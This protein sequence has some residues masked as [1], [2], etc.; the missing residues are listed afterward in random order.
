M[1][2][3]STVEAGVD[4]AAV[5][6][7]VWG[8]VESFFPTMTTL[9]L[10]VEDD[11]TDVDVVLHEGGVVGLAG[12]GAVVVVGVELGVAHGGVVEAEVERGRGRSGRRNRLGEASKT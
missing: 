8:S 6:E 5:L 12:G 1:V 2:V 11:G 4:A 3:A 9:V 7:V 10:L